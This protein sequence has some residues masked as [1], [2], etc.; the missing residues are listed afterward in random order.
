MAADSSRMGRVL[1][2]LAGAVICLFVGLI[3]AIPVQAVE[4]PLYQYSFGPEGPEGASPDF[5]D[6][7]A[8][9]VD[10]Q[11][12]AVYVIDRSTGTLYEFDEAGNPTGQ[13]TGLHFF[14][15]ANESQVAVNSTSHVLYVT[16]S[17]SV[18]ALQ[19]N[20]DPVNFTA[21]SGV[22]TNQIS[23]FGELTGVAVDSNGDIYASDYLG[24][25][26]DIYAPSGEFI[27][28]FST[29]NPANL[30]V[31]PDG[32]VYVS[33]YGGPVT[34]FT[35]NEFP[36]TAST[37][38]TAASEPLDHESSK[39]VA[40]DPTTGNVYIS[41]L[42]P[43]F[44]HSRVVVYDPSGALLTSFGGPGEGEG[45]L[46][47]ITPGVAIKGSS[48][49]VFVSTDDGSGAT[50]R[51]EVEVFAPPFEGAPS[52]LRSSVSDITGDTAVL[53][54]S[55]NPNT[56]DTTYRFEYGTGDC[57][58]APGS[59]TVVQGGSIGAGH[60]PVT[61]SA[62]ISGLQPGTTYHYRVVAVNSFDTTAGPQRVFTTQGSVLGFELSD[63]RAWEMVSPADK[64]AGLIAASPSGAVQAA[65]DGNGVAYVDIGSI[66]AG[67]E[68]SRAV[69][70]ST[71]LSR[72]TSAGWTSKDITLPHAKATTLAEGSEYD[73]FTPDLSKAVVEPRD[74]MPLSPA[75]SERTP[76]LRENSEPPAYTPLV[77]SKEGFANV[78]PGTTF[79][80]DELHG[81]VS[82]VVMDGA[83]DDLNHI[84]LAS[85]VPLVA[86]AASGGGGR[87]LYE[88]ESGQLHPVSALP[89]GGE[90]V[91]GLL[92]S[93]MGSVR[94]AVSDDGSRVFWSTGDIGTSGINLSALYVRDTTAEVTARL[95]VAQPGASEE[96]AVR[97]AFQ[98]ASSDGTV[99]F[100]TDSQQLTTDASPEGR[101]LYRCVIPPGAISDGCASLTDISAPRANPGESA[102]VRG[103][104]AASSEDGTKVYFV[105]SGVLDTGANEVGETATTGQPN[106]YFWQQGAGSRFV[107]TLADEDAPA[108]GQLNEPFG[109][110]GYSHLLTS[111]GSPNGRYF[112]FMSQ[113]SLTGEDEED[114]ASGEA[115]ERVFRYD[116]ITAHLACVSCDPTGADPK[117]QQDPPD[118]VDV[119][120]LWKTQ[121]V[122]ATLPQPTVSAGDLLIRHTVYRPRAVLDNGRVFFNAFGGLVPAD[123]NRNWDVYQYE[124]IGVGSCGASSGGT[125]VSRSGDGCLSLISSGTAEGESSFIDASA[126]G[127]DAFFFTKGKLS[128]T[129]HDTINDVYDARVG[130][131]AAVLNQASECAGDTCRL[132][133]APPN[134]AAPS[135]ETFHGPGNLRPRHCRR[136]RHAV[137]R[138]G[139]VRCVRRKH[140]KHRHQHSRR[141]HSK[142]GVHR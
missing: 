122:S 133:A 53:H 50:T 21:G 54:A 141:A 19:P 78:P 27:T 121:S 12:G 108:W 16:S 14:P 81:Q 7:G 32:S 74:A 1:G 22:G 109:P 64:L 90:I 116:S 11:S 120:A 96:G 110:P 24:N 49:R 33:K 3:C 76:Y 23:G 55:I 106:L 129:D 137:R 136:G 10:Q 67:A 134:A 87:S 92:G 29:S 107:A 86:G 84:V 138:H 51:S 80:G 69:E 73:L 43:D 26:V 142:A 94:N 48:G 112:A 113:R 105:A 39:T 44:K 103:L 91:E 31:A 66:E 5:A 40:V 124:P 135:A 59:C 104:V 57:A 82:E 127:D 100:F 125:A 18:L 46:A 123:S 30:A 89:A 63:S 117:G 34:K 88:W 65:A 111:A 45:E 139:K 71:I 28:E 79:G 101:D 68:G 58:A 41:E 60:T 130:G 25:A 72:R 13:I 115:V 6:V 98:T 38:Y 118:G 35:P 97:P 99:V 62:A 2:L 42:L 131:T 20:G 93:G 15:G 114:P 56:A 70:L 128:V 17:N 119:H 47:N 126:T 8:I 95:D 52:V 85:K 75:S 102:E 9:A 140:R 83:S 36:V 37:L 77:T 61:V 132:D 4:P